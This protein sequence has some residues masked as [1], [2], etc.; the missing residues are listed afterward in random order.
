[1]QPF[2]YRAPD[3]VAAAVAELEEAGDEGRA[4]AGGTALVILMMQ[5]LVRPAR[6]ISLRAIPGLDR[7]ALADGG[8]AIGALATHR[9]VETS[10]VVRARLPVLAETAARVATL[11]IR[12]IATLGGCLAHAD[13][14]QDPPVALLALDARVRVAGPDGERA[15]PLP[16]FFVD[17]YQT[18][19]GPAELVVGVDVPLPAPGTGS[20][21]LKF[22]PR[23][24]DDYATVAAAATVTLD[25]AG[26]CRAARVAL[27]GVAPTPRRV[28]DA[29]RILTGE[30]RSEA[31]LAAAGDAARQAVDPV[32]DHRGSAAYKREMA[33]VFVRRAVAAAW[34]R[35]RGTAA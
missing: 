30:R 25:A 14:N 24:A 13:P 7:I 21:F 19:L 15:L 22:L 12:N 28:P 33:A 20:A 16:A 3:S 27:G 2:D 34:E 11:R 31:L 9:A 29:E 6:V 35:A 26:A 10:P 1:M 5:R 17:Y 32:D 18:A 23:T 8:V 4:I